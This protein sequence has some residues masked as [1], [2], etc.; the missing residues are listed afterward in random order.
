MKKVLYW[1]LTGKHLKLSS[2]GLGK[3]RMT[4]CVGQVRLN[5]DVASKELIL[6]LKKK[7][8]RD[9]KEAMKI[10]LKQAKKEGREKELKAQLKAEKQQ[11]NYIHITLPCTMA[12]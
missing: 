2:M 8:A 11:A 3:N 10:A 4:Y 6:Q 5:V 1:Q 9:K 7:L 12:R